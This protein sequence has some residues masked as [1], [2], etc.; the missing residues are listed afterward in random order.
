[1]HVGLATAGTLS[2]SSSSRVPECRVNITAAIPFD[3]VRD[4]LA[5]RGNKRRSKGH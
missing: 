3:E 5:T 1:M 2:S 4:G